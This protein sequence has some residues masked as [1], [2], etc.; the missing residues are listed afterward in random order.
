MFWWLL[1]GYA[2]LRKVPSEKKEINWPSNF[3]QKDKEFVLSLTQ[4][5]RERFDRRKLVLKADLNKLCI[6][7]DD[8]F[9]IEIGGTK[10]NSSVEY[11]LEYYFKTVMSL[12][13][14]DKIKIKLKR[15][16]EII[17]KELFYLASLEEKE[18]EIK[19]WS[20]R[21]FYLKASRNGN[22]FYLGPFTL[23]QLVDQT[24]TFE[25]EGKIY[26][27]ENLTSRTY[28]VHGN[29]IPVPPHELNKLLPSQWITFGD[30]PALKN[31]ISKS[32]AACLIRRLE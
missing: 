26:K 16:N 23:K 2:A 4:Q 31:I 28:F 29:T 12:K 20:N 11:P 27:I 24:C 3:D 17:E 1:L 6:L 19:Y 5:Q 22:L 7:E 13:D 15:G 9:E 10:L 21:L 14:G 32:A 8:V 30:V 18:E 25:Y